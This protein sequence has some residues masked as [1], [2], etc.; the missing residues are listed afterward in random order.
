MKSPQHIACQPHIQNST[1]DASPV[2][3]PS[4]ELNRRSLLR[5]VFM[6]LGATAI[7]TWMM[8]EA[9]AQ[10]G[11]SEIDV[12]LG[13]LAAQDFGP[14]ELKNVADD[15]TTVNHQLYAPAGFDVRVIM[16]NGFNPV[17]KTTNGVVGH[18]DPDGGA[19]FMHPSDGGWVYVSNEENTPGGVGATRFDAAGNIIDYYRILDGT[20]NNCAGG[21]T[22]WGTWMSCEET[23][24]GYVWECQPF[25][26]AADAVRKDAL[27]ARPGR[28][29]VAVDPINNAIYQTL[30]SGNQPFVRFVSNADDLE[31]LPNGV[32]RMRCESGVSQRLYI[33]AFNELP[34]F[35]GSIPNNSATSAQLRLARPVQWVAETEAHTTFNGGEGIWYYEIPEALRT[36]PA[37]GTVP[38]RGVMFFAT[39]NDGRVWAL[40]LENN[41][42]ELI[43][44]GQNGQAFENLRPGQPA[45]A[46]WNQ[47]DNVVVSPSGDAMVAED[48]SNMRLAI[49]I[50][51]Q[52][53]KLLMQITAGNSEITGPAFTPDGSRLYF[54]RQNGP[55]VPGRLTR[56]TT[57]EMTIPPAF[58]AIQKADAFSF[59]ERDTGAPATTITSEPVV[60]TGFLGVLTVSIGLVNGAQFSIDGGSWTNQPSAI[61]AGQSLR[62]RHTSAALVGEAAE[63][64]VT[65][66]S[67]S[68]AS[69]QS[70]TFRTSTS[71][72]DTRP[73]EFDFGMVE[74]VPGNSLTESAV[75]TLSG[76]NM[77]TPIK[78]G[79]HCE[80]RIDG[81]QWTDAKGTLAPYQTLQM[82]HISNKPSNSV[83]RTHLHVGNV[84]GHFATR[85]A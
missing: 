21:A 68:P 61:E 56:G 70:A 26:T 67:L 39:K 13:P 76:F 16:R 80:Y 47:V 74:D 42:I 58:R 37:A 25:G 4:L 14:L 27:G 33:P 54:S 1:T 79:P 55:N 60:V 84:P 19:V 28:E 49:V 7:P 11:S 82:R 43:V 30:D 81:G 50:N 34:A 22:P 85:T 24:G 29:A 73:D 15:I 8:Q 48:G 20:R 45:L 35:N 62:V 5:G 63:T 38:T 18:L 66:G 32:T 23:S 46:N 17:S 3:S 71:E 31:V 59:N 6:G 83:R 77:P 36:T 10:S 2:K 65:I 40:D 53:S 64:I 9:M 57:Y 75:I 51:N 72:P 52:P 12:P 69:L 41:L 44:D 78:C